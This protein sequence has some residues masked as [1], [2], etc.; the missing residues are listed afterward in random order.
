M[1]SR[2]P[3]QPL[4]WQLYAR[5]TGAAC[6]GHSCVSSTLDHGD[7]V[8]D[9]GTIAFNLEW[10]PLK[11]L[12]HENLFLGIPPHPCIRDNI[13]G[14]HSCVVRYSDHYVRCIVE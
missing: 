8:V 13:N 5:C 11:Y 2:S 7:S 6:L 4:L 14:R 1:P 10:G 12:F 9:N 3:I